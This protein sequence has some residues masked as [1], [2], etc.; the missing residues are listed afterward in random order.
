MDVEDE[1]IRIILPEGASNI[2]WSTPFDIDSESRDIHYT[3]LDT[4]G[5]PVLIL[6]K[7]NVVRMHNQYFQV[8]HEW[9]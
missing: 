4:T 1:T 2:Q 3:Y 7:Y 6:N 9:E 5:R 8:S